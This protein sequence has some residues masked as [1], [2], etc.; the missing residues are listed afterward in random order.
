M[1]SITR[2]RWNRRKREVPR[3][4]SFLSKRSNRTWTWMIRSSRCPLRN[5]K[6]RNQRLE[7][8]LPHQEFPRLARLEDAVALQ[9]RQG[10][11]RH[12]QV[13]SLPC[14]C[15]DVGCWCAAFR[16]SWL[17]AGSQVRLGHHFWPRRAEHWLGRDERPRRSHCRG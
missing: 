8:D 16:G 13:N 4:N 15:D 17:S 5:Q 6:P 14:C 10:Y 3:A 12:E 7:N 9:D 1:E 11:R 2:L